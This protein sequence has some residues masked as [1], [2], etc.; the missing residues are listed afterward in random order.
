MLRPP[1]G[2]LLASE[3]GRSL[4]HPGRRRAARE[5]A[6]LFRLIRDTQILSTARRANERDGKMKIRLMTIYDRAVRA[7]R[8][9]AKWLIE[10]FERYTEGARRALFFARAHRRFCDTMQ[11]T[12]TAAFMQLRASVFTWRKLRAGR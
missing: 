9:R 6:H 4:S 8:L 11:P 3:T 1:V 2:R 10:M 5:D 7:T 12:H